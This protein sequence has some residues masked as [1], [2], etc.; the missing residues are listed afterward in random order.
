M[1]K[2]NNVLHVITP[3]EDSEKLAENWNREHFECAS[4]MLLQARLSPVFW[5]DAVAYSQ[6]LY[7]R[8]PNERL[9]GFVAP[10]T[11]VTGERP[12]FDKLRVFGCDCYLHIPNNPFAKVPGIPKGRKLI[13]VGFDLQAHG[14]RVF[15]PETRRYTSA[16]NLYFNEDFTERICALR[17]FDK[18]RA[19]M[20]KGMDQPVVLDDFS[21]D[22]YDQMD[23]VRRL[24][25]DP[26]L[27]NDQAR[28]LSSEGASLAPVGTLTPQ[29]QPAGSETPAVAGGSEVSK[30]PL[31]Q[32]ALRAAKA[33]EVI[34][35]SKNL[36]PLRLS[37]IGVPVKATSEDKGFL[38]HV[39]LVN[40]PVAYLR[41]CPKKGKS[42]HRYVKYMYATTLNEAMRLGA[43]RD[44]ILWDHERGFI[45]YPTL[46]PDLPGHV[47]NCLEV[48]AAH[49]VTHV[50]EDYG[51]Y[52]RKDD[53]TD[54]HL[55]QVC[56]AMLSKDTRRP[57]FGE[58]V[59]QAFEPDSMLKLFEE[60]ER[61]IRFA[62]YQAAKV[63]SSN[64]DPETRKI[65]FSIAPEPT[66]FEEVQPEVCSEAAQ[67]KD[68]MDEEIYS[69]TKY[70]VY[71]YV[72]KSEASGRQI[73]GA[74]WVYKRKIGKDGQV[75]R[76]RAR[77]VAQ[78]FRQKAY[79]SFNPD[80]TYSPVVHK[81]TLRMFLSV[82][83]AQDL[84]VHVFDVT[85]AFLQAPLSEKIF[86]RAPPG[87]TKVSSDGEEM[88]LKL[89][90]AIYGLKQSSNAF[91]QAL[92]EHLTS[93]G[94]TAA[95]GDPC[96]FRKVLSDGRV[97]LVCCYVDDISIGVSDVSLVDMF[98]SELRERF[99][100]GD[101]QGKPVDWLLGMAI[102]QD[103]KAG[104]VHMN[105]E[106]MIKKLAEGILSEQEL[107]RSASVL[108]PMLVEPLLKQSERS[109]SKEVFDYLSVV[110]S[111]L[112]ICN[113]VRC[114]VS[115]AVGV[116]A[117]HATTPGL[118]HV[119]A[120]KRV[121]MYLYN[122]RTMGIT[123]RRTEESKQS[124]PVLFEGTKHPL[125]DGTNRLQT[126][127]DSDYAGSE[128][129]RSTMGMVFMLSGG[130]VSWCS[131]LG[132][133][134]ALSTCEAEVNAACLAAKEALHLSQLLKDIGY[135]EEVKPL[136][137]AEDNAACI[138]QV[139]GGLRHVRKAK[140]YEVKLAFL[141]QLVVEEKIGFVYCPT[142]KQ[143]ADLF[144][145]SLEKEK[146]IHFR[147]LIFGIDRV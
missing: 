12:R 11:L 98:M 136:Q 47:H 61:A 144:T 42:A 30:G 103:L 88:V 68:A 129:R 21:A 8:T 74:R 22:N 56:E 86:L 113:C 57:D 48:A 135:N 128:T 105:M 20:K 77:L 104:T 58:V 52:V 122:T 40:A 85:A 121:V 102:T 64:V 130:P 65:D 84:S 146:F 36:R 34:Q 16:T 27:S 45:K 29:T 93:K 44:D 55:K 92:K 83:A 26:D 141:Q 39:R 15:D 3:V 127:A 9:G 23:S 67:W 139:S 4:A 87:Y 50:L 46:E 143:Y 124:G 147:N 1:C 60:R 35:A 134:V 131:V 79:D 5:A 66:R 132:K 17:H 38:D 81:D 82:C 142:E 96:L 25:L 2:K 19:L 112:H 110:G 13:F 106:R 72:K 70:G 89:S 109:V 63:M 126:F 53:E 76:Y 114:D 24:Y 6:F 95:L 111:L 138:A 32:D 140:H 54:F 90:K 41:P 7:N 51:T 43:T 94:Y 97:I 108:T 33:R 49:G 118:A 37:A 71:D 125:D 107:V 123:Y 120:A 78:G 62:E 137:I 14:W 28:E 115:Y 100:V 69:M 145:K 10:I 75:Y 117:R 59:A 101:D 80:E 91:W 18:R 73:L 99:D 133:T 119:K 31:S 116:L